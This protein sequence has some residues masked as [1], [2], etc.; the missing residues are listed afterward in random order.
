[1]A[2]MIQTKLFRTG[3]SV[4]LRIPAGW[5]DPAR[6]VELFRDPH[7]GRVYA[8]QNNDVD[9]QDFFDFLRGKGFE[10][11]PEFESLAQREEAPRVGP[12]LDSG[13]V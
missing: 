2:D 11:D 7:T 9:T 6:P 1:M 12:L 10:P 8:T 5:L 3:G 13:A 4:A